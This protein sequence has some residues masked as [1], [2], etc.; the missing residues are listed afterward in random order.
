MLKYRC[1]FYH[2][3]SNYDGKEKEMVRLNVKYRQGS[4]WKRE[5]VE[6]VSCALMAWDT[7]DLNA[8]GTRISSLNATTHGSCVLCDRANEHF[9]PKTYF[10][11]TLCTNA[12]ARW[13]TEVC[14]RHTTTK[15]SSLEKWVL[16]LDSHAYKSLFLSLTGEMVYGFGNVAHGDDDDDDD[17]SEDSNNNKDDADDTKVTFA[18]CVLCAMY[19]VHVKLVL[20][21]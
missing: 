18:V 2:V 10:S 6:W 11:Y 8:G 15:T 19:Y 3:S 12:K 17:D 13:Q 7:S 14:K 1:I 20:C 21:K 16:S 4:G 9:A 5:K